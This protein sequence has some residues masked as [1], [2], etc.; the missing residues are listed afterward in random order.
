M[1]SAERETLCLFVRVTGLLPSHRLFLAGS[2]L[3]SGVHSLFTSMARLTGCSA[4]MKAPIRAG[5]D[6]ATASG[7]VP[8]LVPCF[9][10]LLSPRCRCQPRPVLSPCFFFPRER[11]WKGKS[12]PCARTTSRQ[13]TRLESSPA[14]T[15]STSTG[16]QTR[17]NKRRNGFRTFFTSNSRRHFCRRE[18]GRVEQGVRSLGQRARP[19]RRCPPVWSGTPEE[20]RGGG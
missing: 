5:R 11:R 16:E 18:S 6:D 9:P 7:P 20:G 2:P 19:R 4:K 12:V 1:Q 17:M 14:N 15:P 10:Y 13:G 8:Q 3:S